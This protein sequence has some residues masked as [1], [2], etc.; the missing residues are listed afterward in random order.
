M[1]A[2]TLGYVCVHKKSKYQSTCI[3]HVEHTDSKK[4]KEKQK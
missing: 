2:Q 3:K 1:Y 4:T